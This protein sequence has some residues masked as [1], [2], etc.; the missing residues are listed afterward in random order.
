[1]QV[2]NIISERL[3]MVWFLLGLLFAVLS[4]L[5]YWVAVILLGGALGYQLTLGLLHWIGF[6]A[7][8]TPGRITQVPLESL[9]GYALRAGYELD[10]LTIKW[11]NGMATGDP[12]LLDPVYTGKAMSALID[13]IT[14]GKLPPHEPVLFLHTGG[15]P[16]LFGYAEEV[17]ASIPE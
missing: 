6:E 9:G 2:I 5:Y 8:G 1:M 14:T 13:D 16:A 11:E 12:D 3:P 17:L 15:A 4:Y 7:D 10:W